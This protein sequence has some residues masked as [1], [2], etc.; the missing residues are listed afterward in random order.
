[1]RTELSASPVVVYVYSSLLVVFGVG[2]ALIDPILLV[3]TALTVPQGLLGFSFRRVFLDES[4]FIFIRGSREESIPF[5]QVQSVSTGL[6]GLPHLVLAHRTQA[7]LRRV[8]F[9]PEPSHGSFFLRNFKLKR[10]LESIIRP[11]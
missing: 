5:G 2:I 6:V 8:R 7:G 1:M 9:F 3:L 10:Q 4:S 11:S